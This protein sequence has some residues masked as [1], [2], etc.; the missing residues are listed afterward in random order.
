MPCRSSADP[1]VYEDVQVM[2]PPTQT[3]GFLA[4]IYGLCQKSNSTELAKPEMGH[5]YKS[6]SSRRL[7]ACPNMLL[8][9]KYPSRFS[10]MLAM[11]L[12]GSRVAYSVLG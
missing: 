11:L 8:E 7:W 12:R 9:A 2:V 6:T 10:A 4:Y 3:N 5:E 1:T